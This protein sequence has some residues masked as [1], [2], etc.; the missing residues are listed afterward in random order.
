M[1]V[2][3]TREARAS[4]SSARYLWAMRLAGRLASLPLT[5]ASDAAPM[6]SVAFLTEAAP[7]ARLLSH[8]G[9]S[10]RPSPIA[11]ARGSPAWD[12]ALADAVPDWDTLAQ[13][14]PEYLLDQQAQW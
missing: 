8:L 5:C 4:G 9:E 7:G 10:A 1:V 2:T 14:E 3:A 11:P 6:R 13:P 12:D